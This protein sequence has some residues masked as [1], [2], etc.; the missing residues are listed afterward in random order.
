MPIYRCDALRVMNVVCYVEAE[1]LDEAKWKF[2]KGHY[3]EMDPDSTG[4]DEIDCYVDTARL[5]EPVKIV[6]ESK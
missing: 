5:D 3:T 2:D 4:G 6:G 1:S